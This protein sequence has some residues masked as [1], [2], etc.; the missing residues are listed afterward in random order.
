MTNAATARLFQKPIGEIVGQECFR[1]FEKRDEVC[2][3]C[4]GT[5]AMAT[6]RKAVVETTGVRDDGSRFIVRLQAFPQRGPDGRITGFIEVVEDITERK[7]AGE[8]LRESEERFRLVFEKAPIGI[9]HYD[10]TSTV[11]EC[12]EKFAEIIGA[13]KEK[14]IGF[15]MIRQLQDD[16][17]RKAVAASLGGQVGYYEGDYL[18]VTAGKLTPVRAIYQPIF[19]P[20]GVISGGITIFEDITERQRAESELRLKERLLDSASDSIFL[21]DLEGNFLYVNEAAYI[22]RWYRKEEL[23]S[24]GAWA[25]KTPEAAVY[26]DNILRELWANGELIFESEHRRK[27]GSVI[28]VEIFARI[29]AVEGRELILSVARDITERKQAETQV[30]QGLDSLHQALQGTVVA[31]ANTVEIKDPY[32]AGHQRRVAQLS[33]AMARELGWPADRIEGIQVLCFLHDLGKIAV[34]AEILN[35]PGKISPT[36]FSLIKVHPQV[37]YDILK[38]IAFPWPVAQ[39]VLQ[40]H[41][42]LDGSG[43]PSGL[44]AEEITPEAKILAVADVVEAMVSHRPY[45]PALGISEALEEIT[46]NRGKLYDPDAVDVCIR[47]LTEKDFQFD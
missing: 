38:D 25:L 3:H 34:P 47:L 13:P 17:M 2:P 40:H 8:A 43:Y 6:G 42:R 45:R 4:P 32:T 22:T 21:Y 11:T 9:M 46:P 41:E 14:F 5:K 31:L 33:C 23:L 1:E 18:S 7:A 28:P 44:T 20:E 35:K 12:N 24:L 26:Q 37:G 16:Q 29:L 30:R 10:Q 36:E 27:D 15:N 19:S 39:G